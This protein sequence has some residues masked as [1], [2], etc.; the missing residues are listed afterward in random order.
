V[1][2]S[3][4]EQV[5]VSSDLD[6]AVIYSIADR[7]VQVE[8]APALL[9]RLQQRRRTAVEA[10]TSGAAVYG[11]NT[12][13]GA[14]STTR[15]TAEQQTRQQHSLLKARA[16]GGPPWLGRKEARAVLAMRLRTLLQGDAG[17][18]PELCQALVRLLDADLLPAIPVH[19]GGS[20]GEIIP[21]SHAF[22]PLTGIGHFLPKEAVGDFSGQLLEASEGLAGAGLD[23]FRLGPKEGI[24]LLQGIPGTLALALLVARSARQLF[25]Q[26]LTVSALSIA[27]SKGSRDPYE[28]STA[29]GDAVLAQVLGQIRRLAGPEDA[30]RALQAPV[31]F[32]V[33]GPTLANL[34]RAVRE[35]EASI[36]RGLNAVSD[37]PAFLDD[38]FVGTTGFHGVDVASRLD[39]L[40][41]AF[42]SV[43][44]V[45]AARLHRLLEERVTGL[46]RQLARVPGPETGMVNVHK[47]AVGEA[48]LLRRAAVPSAVGTMETS[49]GQEDVQS[50]SWEAA[51]T[52]RWAVERTRVVIACELLAACRAVALRR[53]GGDGTEAL[54]A[55]LNGFVAR[56]GEEVPDDL[57]DR[58]FGVDIQKLTELLENGLGDT[59]SERFPDQG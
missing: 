20:A 54:P 14:A 32:R 12:G 58:T 18:S 41:S 3:H 13:L 57:V 29:R 8:L 31:S 38:R 43:A 46:P 24:A 33:A 10:L 48:H 50:F 36:E 21:M 17:V 51:Q 37:S 6:F 22:G 55:E 44:E 7:R 5:S 52:S 19:A 4:S 25:F 53:E 16:V 1:S 11:V 35:L 47:R 23:A 26:S 59:I 15:L 28:E 56:V 45:S 42:V 34:W 30:P 40:N 9:E 39:T 49:L 27:V 2:S